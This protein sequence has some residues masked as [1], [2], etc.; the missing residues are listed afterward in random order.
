[1]IV[2]DTCQLQR[3]VERCRAIDD[4]NRVLGTRVRGQ[5]CLEAVH[6]LSR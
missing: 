1:M 2:S 6:K 5:I 4:G 3:N